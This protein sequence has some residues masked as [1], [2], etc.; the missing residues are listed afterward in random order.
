MVIAPIEERRR[1][2][3]LNNRIFILCRFRKKKNVDI[4]KGFT[5][6]ISPGGLMFETDRLIPPQ[7]VLN[8]EIYQPLSQFSR[9]I[10][11]IP[12]LA[13]VKW[14]T[15]MNIADKY[16]GSNKYRIGVEFAKIDARERK[17]IAEYVQDKLS[18]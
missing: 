12:I 11:S 8:L 9:G 17:V 10:I 7:G 15:E 6:D 1:F 13:K 4:I 3:R 5:N 16:K 2:S 18:A 14:V